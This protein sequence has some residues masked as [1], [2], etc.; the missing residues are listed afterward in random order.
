MKKN[1]LPKEGCQFIAS[2]IE[3]FYELMNDNNAK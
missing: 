1:K 2:E 3:E